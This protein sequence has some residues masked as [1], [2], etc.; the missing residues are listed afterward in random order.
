MTFLPIQAGL[1]S[2]P[3]NLTQKELWMLP[4]YKARAVA[5]L[6]CPNPFH[7]KITFGYGTHHHKK[8]TPEYSLQVSPD[9]GSKVYPCTETSQKSG[10]PRLCMFRLSLRTFHLLRS[11]WNPKERLPPPEGFSWEPRRIRGP[12]PRIFT[13]PRQ[14][15]CTRKSQP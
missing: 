14:V 1:T 13:W 5:L 10:Y 11:R 12:T 6:L 4:F 15:Q 8:K 3:I 2:T 7:H 9:K